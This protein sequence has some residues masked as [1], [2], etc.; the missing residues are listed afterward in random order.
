MH[1][2]DLVT[3]RS[4]TMFTADIESKKDRLSA[5]IKGKESVSDW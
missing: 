5:E 2:P 1:T 3:F 4:I